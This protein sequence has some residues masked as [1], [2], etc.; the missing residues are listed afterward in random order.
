ML[1]IAYLVFFLV[2]VPFAMARNRI[3]GLYYTTLYIYSAFSIAGY[4]YI[5][6]LSES[7]DAY[8]GNS[9]GRE[10][11][12]FVFV[13]MALFWAVNMKLYSNGPQGKAVIIAWHSPVVPTLGVV[14]LAAVVV[15]FAGLL[16]I[17]FADLSWYIFED[18]LSLPL[19]TTLF[20]LVYKTTVGILITGYLV[21]RSKDIETNRVFRFLYGVLLLSFLVASARLGNRTDPTAF[22][23][24]VILFEAL[25]RELRLRS[26]VGGA[27]VALLA[28]LAISAIEFYRYR[29]GGAGGPLLE[30]IVRNDYFAP[31]HMLFSAV[32]F[33]YINPMAVIRSNTANALILFGEPY[34]QQ[35]VTELFR[36]DVATRSAG[37]AFYILTEGWIFAGW[38]G[39]FY[40]ALIPSA[41]LWL[42]NRLSST[43]N[44]FA[45]LLVQMLVASML[46]NVTRGQSSYFIKYL[47]T[48]ILPNIGLAMLIVGLR[49]SLRDQNG[50]KPSGVVGT[51]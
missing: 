11:L 33:D 9:V 35:T 21:V 10:S 31:A 27:I 3:F 26:I 50:R 1:S 25:S 38:W 30:R 48:F 14:V 4:L 15:L 13:S 47:Y 46:V 51:A 34:L 39:V 12:A 8:F 6:G 49:F 29:D 19:K 40:N 17:N 7:I 5:P 32:A 37:Y 42:W 45:N 20:I 41:G 23:L 22:L 18:S 2:T 44:R 24:G 16:A 28:V 36:G 43:N